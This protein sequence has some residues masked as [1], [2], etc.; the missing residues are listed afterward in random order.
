MK[1]LAA[2]RPLGGL[3]RTGEAKAPSRISYPVTGR[4]T[5]SDVP[6]AWTIGNGLQDGDQ[7]WPDCCD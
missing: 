4:W 6:P 3:S 5:P 2:P 7:I 1:R